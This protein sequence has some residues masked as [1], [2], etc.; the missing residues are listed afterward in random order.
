MTRTLLRTL[1]G[2]LLVV[3][4]AKAAAPQDNQLW[5]DLIAT[6]R[7]HPRWDGFVYG[8]LRF[9][10]GAALVWQS[11]EAGFDFRPT[12]PLLLS[13]AYEFIHQ[14]P[15]P[16]NNSYENRARMTVAGNLSRGGFHVSVQNLF[17]YLFPN[18]ASSFWRDR[19]RLTVAHGVGPGRWA[20]TPYVSDE[21]FYDSSA[22]AW[23]RNRFFAGVKKGLGRGRT[24]EV[25][26]CRQ[27]DSSPSPDLNIVGIALRLWFKPRPTPDLPEHPI[28]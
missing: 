19:P 20:L 28:G 12:R 14:E 25:Y 22:Q 15:A 4:A 13:A 6:T 10:D 9:G 3:V 2:A 27:D 18:G 11:G 26:Y 23:N 21:V 5:T 24:L 17:E 16:G 7:L 8:Q 1:L